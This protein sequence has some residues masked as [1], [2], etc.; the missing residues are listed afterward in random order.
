MTLVSHS[1][2]P[3]FQDIATLA[4]LSN[5]ER[6][7]LTGEIFWFQITKYRYYREGLRYAKKT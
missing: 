4:S 6:A 2:G 3:F 5:L 1:D 7:F